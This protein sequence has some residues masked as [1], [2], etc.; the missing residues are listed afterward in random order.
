MLASDMPLS[1]ATDTAV[2]LVE[3]TENFQTLQPLSGPASASVQKW[4]VSLDAYSGRESDFS[5]LLLISIQLYGSSRAAV[6]ALD[7]MLCP[8]RDCT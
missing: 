3:W 4:L 2:A 7:T 8:V 6:R 1:K 5:F